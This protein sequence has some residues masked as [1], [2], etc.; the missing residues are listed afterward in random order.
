MKIL[1][2][3]LL[4]IGVF[5]F[6][7][8]FLF[9]ILADR[10]LLLMKRHDLKRAEKSKISKKSKPNR[11][12]E[13]LTKDQKKEQKEFDQE[14]ENFRSGVEIYD[15]DNKRKDVALAQEQ[16]QI[17]DIVKPVGRFSAMIIKQKMGFLLAVAGLQSAAGVRPKNYWQT[18]IKAQ[19][20]TKS[21][22]KG[23]GRG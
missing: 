17:V 13:F 10:Y 3:I 18:V 15:P 23:Q 21:F 4:L 12:D 7:I 8:A 9:R 5:A 19:E 22:N 1:L 11:P 2:I 16:P 20:M 6:S 14:L